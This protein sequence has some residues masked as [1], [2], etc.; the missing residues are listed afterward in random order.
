[1]TRAEAEATMRRLAQIFAT[2]AGD[3]D[4]RDDTVRMTRQF[5]VTLEERARAVATFLAELE[6]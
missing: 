2:A 1:M 4:P 5:C 3:C 6:D